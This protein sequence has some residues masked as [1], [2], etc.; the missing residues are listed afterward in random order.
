[1]SQSHSSHETPAHIVDALLVFDTDT[2]LERYPDASRSP[3]APS[4]ADVECCFLLAPGPDRLGAFND[5]R[6]RVS[7]PVGSFLRLRPAT[8]ALRA[9]YAVLLIAVEWGHQDTLS[10]LKF[11]FDDQ[12]EISVPQMADPAK[13]ARYASVDHF[14][15]A[16]VL[17][18]GSVDVRVDAMIADRNAGILGCFR[19]ELVFDVLG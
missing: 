19:W 15:Q 7:A 1:M 18:H 13:T 8:L 9:E 17:A 12:A 2:L 10:G 16:Q 6:L 5:G 3:D 4:P 11:C 14:W